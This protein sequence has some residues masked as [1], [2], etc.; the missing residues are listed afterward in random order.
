MVVATGPY[1]CMNMGWSEA[2]RMVASQSM[3]KFK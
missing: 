1:I 2:L 3:G